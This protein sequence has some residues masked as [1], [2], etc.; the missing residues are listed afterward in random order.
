MMRDGSNGHWV[1]VDM[2]RTV[3]GI[4]NIKDSRPQGELTIIGNRKTTLRP[5]KF[6]GWFFYV[7]YLQNINMNVSNANRNRPKVIIS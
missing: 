7:D 6:Q 1:K 2:V 4:E 3:T 5:S